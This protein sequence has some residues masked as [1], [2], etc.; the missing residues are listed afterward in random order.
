MSMNTGKNRDAEDAENGRR[1]REPSTLTF[2]FSG[3]TENPA[4]GD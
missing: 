3:G 2:W 1:G 4:E